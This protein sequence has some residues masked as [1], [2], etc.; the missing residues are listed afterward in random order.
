[1]FDRLIKSVEEYDRQMEEVRKLMEEKTCC[2]KSYEIKLTSTEVQ[3]LMS[4]IADQ[5]GHYMGLQVKLSEINDVGNVIYNSKLMIENK[6]NIL[7]QIHNYLE[8]L[9]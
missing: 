1:M 5:L 7:T 4:A 2:E 3:S 9:R 8:N 6:K